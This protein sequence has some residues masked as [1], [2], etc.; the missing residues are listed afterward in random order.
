MRFSFPALVA[1]LTASAF[2]L[3]GA[4]SLLVDHTEPSELRTFASEAE[5]V[6]FLRSHRADQ[7]GGWGLFDRSNTAPAM[8]D[9]SGHSGT[10][11]QVAGVDEGDMVKT[12]GQYIYISDGSAVHVVLAYPADALSNVTVISPPAEQGQ[13]PY[14]S[15][16]YLHEDR[17]IIIHSSY[18]FEVGVPYALADAL[19][20]VP[21]WDE[22]ATMV[23][24]YDITDP[25]RP[26]L[27]HQSGV[28]GWYVG[29]RMVDGFVYAVTQK[30]VWAGDTVAVPEVVDGDR[31]SKV[32]ATEV[33]YDPSANEA[34]SFISLLAVDA[35]SGESSC[36]PV[37]G[38][39]SSIMYMSTTSLYLTTQKWPSTW[40]DSRPNDVTTAIY[41]LAVDGL[42]V[43]LAA[44]G[45]VAGHP[46]SQFSLDEHDGHL[47]VA[48][49]SGWSEPSTAVTVLDLDLKEVGRLEG[50]APGETMYASRFID[51]RLYLVTAIRV[52]PLFVVDL[53]DPAAPA[54][55]GELKV[56]GI[57][58][59]L[60]MTE[61]GLLGI[62]TDNGTLKVSLFDVTDDA[63]REIDTY[64]FAGYAYSDGQWDHHAVLWDE[65]YDLLSLPVY[66]WGMASSD[67]AW[68]YASWSALVTLSV[69]EEGI[70]LRGSVEH[71]DAVQRSLYIGDLL[72]SIST[73]MVKVSHLPDLSA[74]AEL[75]FREFPQYW[76]GPGAAVF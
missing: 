25:A 33:H 4:A 22:Q 26:V 17:L 76:Y 42:N 34:T 12:D 7:G 73:T 47:R 38:S 23:S 55:R 43:T 28:S 32:R 66:G 9:A 45:S 35:A 70:E 5:M 72:Y 6:S 41:R 44:Q 27:V 51:D 16:M 8:E 61:H 13:H 2:V 1:V 10:N 54:L 71:P 52:D 30:N 57:S 59:Y 63:P 62:G 19:Y 48:T 3:G 18:Q 40:L 75:T 21:S 39:A 37:V 68:Y 50:I 36:L 56:P 20:K 60:Q 49:S 14:I 29:S 64:L 31:P 65:R 46:I 67:D 24:I 11:T 53:S 15:A 74:E 69:T 58:T